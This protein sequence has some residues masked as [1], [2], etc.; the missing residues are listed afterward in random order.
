MHSSIILHMCGGMMTMC[1]P[2]AC[3]SNIFVRLRSFS[4]DPVWHSDF[5]NDSVSSESTISIFKR[6]K[7]RL[8]NWK[9]F[10][11]SRMWLL[12]HALHRMIPTILRKQVSELFQ[13]EV[14]LN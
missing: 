5:T 7:N 12:E 1:I 8:A 10:L 2:S 4:V 13:Q 14:S 6:Q 3:E 9:V 11:L